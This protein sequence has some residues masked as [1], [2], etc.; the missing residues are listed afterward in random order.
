MAR[1]FEK[2]WQ[3]WPWVW[4]LVAFAEV[5]YLQLTRYFGAV[6]PMHDLASM[7]QAVW[8]ASQGHLLAFTSAKGVHTSRLLSHAEVVYFLIAPL[9][10]LFPSAATLLV[11]EAAVYASA[12]WPV[13][14]LGERYGKQ[15]RWAVL[16]YLF[17]PVA[18]TAALAEFHSDP[19]AMAFLLWALDAM[20]ARRWRWFA[21]WTGMVLICKTYMAVPVLLLAALLWFRGERRKAALTAAAAVA[22]GV[23]SFVLLKAWVSPLFRVTTSQVLSGYVGWRYGGDLWHVLA[24][25]WPER[26]GM[27][28][29]VI[30]PVLPWLVLDP[31]SAALA[32]ALILPAVSTV[33]PT[34]V[35]YY[36]HYAVAVPFLVYGALRGSMALRARAPR[37]WRYARIWTG[38]IE[39]V[40]V[41][42]GVIWLLFVHA[43]PAQ[44]WR[45]PQPL[46]RGHAVMTWAQARIAP[47]EPLLVSANLLPMFATRPW[48]TQT[49]RPLLWAKVAP[50]RVAL[51]DVFQEGTSISGFFMEV[52]RQALLGL[53][54]DP[55]GWV[56]VDVY[57]G[58]FLLRRGVPADEALLWKLS[59][60]ATASQ[61]SLCAH[62]ALAAAVDFGNGIRLQCFEAAPDA[63]GVLHVR[64]VWQRVGQT[65]LQ[66]AY[67]VTTVGGWAPQGERLVH[68]PAWLGYAPPRWRTGQ[69]VVEEMT[70]PLH[71]G[72]GCYPVRVG[73]F[74]PVDGAYPATSAT[75]RWGR[76]VVLGAVQ[77]SPEGGAAWLPACPSGGQ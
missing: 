51:V 46:Q 63:E 14:R 48:L 59:L 52:E 76:E 74:V 30:A 16:L 5:A 9:M 24:E 28:F 6:Y 22:W 60:P 25:T 4:A 73:W 11:V 54:R 29:I 58:T 2:R 75:A 37:L 21:F 3:W 26:V 13:Y 56:L 15:G 61:A 53:Q 57:D 43:L 38:T 77:V 72:A 20:E 12:A 18:Q 34:Y 65:P 64:F 27:V 8:S 39:A 32:L 33:I 17:Y 68:L 67:A 44:P 35:Y 62:N 66:D 1:G 45:N 10:R 69:V 47:D 50:A 55:R 40:T 7:A 23:F 42:V 36:H 41:V 49:Y 19:L 70:W 31:L 71:L